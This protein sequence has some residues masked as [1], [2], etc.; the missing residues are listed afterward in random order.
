MAF[1]NN[2]IAGAAGAGSADDYLVNRSLRLDENTQGHLHFQPSQQGNRRKYTFSCWFKRAKLTG[3]GE[4]KLWGNS[5]SNSAYTQLYFTNTD[6]LVWHIQTGYLITDRHFK[7][8]SAWYHVVVQVDTDQAAAANRSK[9][10]INGELIQYPSE[11]SSMSW[12]S[13]TYQYN[14]T[15]NDTSKHTLSG[16]QDYSN[17]H[18]FDGL[19]AEVN[20]I[21]GSYLDASS[22]GLFH[23]DTGEWVPKKYSGSYGT[24]GYYLDFSNSS[25]IGEDQSGRGNN[26]TTANVD[27]G[28]IFKDSPT[29][30]EE[31][32][33]GN[34]TTLNFNDSPNVDNGSLSN[35]ALDFVG[36]QQ[37][38][39]MLRATQPI[40]STG[41]WY[42][43]AKFQG[44]AYN[45]RNLGSQHTAVGFCKTH[46]PITGITDG[47]STWIADS[48]YGTVFGSTRTDWHG[49][50]VDQGAVVGVAINR[51]ANQAWF[52]VNGVK[53]Q[54]AGLGKHGYEDLSPFVYSYNNT[55]ASL[56]CNFGQ[57][58]FSHYPV[59]SDFVENA[60]TNA[61]YNATKLFDGNLST[62]MS[63]GSFNSTAYWKPYLTDVT[64][65]RVYLQTGSR[66]EQIVIRGNLGNQTHTFSA[67]TSLSWHTLS[68]TN[69][70]SNLDIMEIGPR[71][72]GGEYIDVAAVEI[73]GTILTDSDSVGYKTINTANLDEPAIADPADAFNVQTYQGTSGEKAITTGFN[74]DIVWVKN[75]SQNRWH[76]LI[77]SI[78]GV[79]KNLYPNEDDAESANDTN[80]Y[81]SF[82]ATGYTLFGLDRDTNS[83]DGDN[84]ASWAWE[85]G[86]LATARDTTNYNQSQTWSS[87]VTSSNT[88]F[89]FPFETGF[90]GQVTGDGGVVG[91]AGWTSNSVTLTFSNLSASSQ[92]IVYAGSGLNSSIS[93]TINIGGSNYTH[94]ASSGYIN[95]LSFSYSGAVTTLALTS[96]GGGVRFYGI[97][98]DG[99]VLIDPGIIPI[100]DLNDLVYDRSQ[101]WSSMITRGS[102]W[103]HASN[104][105]YEWLL[106]GN[107]T[108]YEHAAANQTGSA[109]FSSSFPKGVIELYIGRGGGNGG[110][111]TVNG[112][113]I[114]ASDAPGHNWY[115]VSGNTLSS[116]S[117]TNPAQNVGIAAIRV[118]GKILADPSPS[119]DIT[120]Y[121][122]RPTKVT[123]NTSSGVSVSTYDGGGGY[124][125]F[126]HGL[127]GKQ[128]EMVI[129][130]A[131][132]AV[133]DWRV[134]HQH[135]DVTS[136]QNYYL[137][138]DQTTALSS[139][140]GRSLFDR[141]GPSPYVMHLGN[142]SAVNGAGRN[143]VAF[144]FAP[145]K[146]FS[147]FG[148]YRK[149]A[150][151]GPFA[152][153]GFRPAW[154]MIRRTDNS[155]S[156]VIYDE[157]R[158]PYNSTIYRLYADDVGAEGSNTSHYIDIFSNGFKVR[159]PQGNLL[160][161]SD[162]NAYY[163][164]A[165]FSSSPFKTSRAR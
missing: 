96:G 161:S 19:I 16:K 117:V 89:Q 127:N 123:A 138:W 20:F 32:D 150:G 120:N 25:N 101:T 28:D 139:D 121:P 78:R 64:S 103:H 39:S 97:K 147:E 41:K 116:I 61:S 153:C 35:G 122:G 81:K 91:F 135:L 162:T 98:V 82:D 26:W 4:H 75:R 119:Y 111:L 106:D 56:E 100:G 37:S 83:A 47:N 5:V 140:Q 128:P 77:D 74:P 84:Y 65:L 21:D 93:A 99:K 62:M 141:V 42:Y 49:A 60:S 46:E 53:K 51:E 112:F 70:G 76:R 3:T 151:D 145:V 24:N 15:I 45:P 118:N 155:N 38:Y 9:I 7:D 133:D 12:T 154:V 148:Y 54:V 105:F 6:K 134:F 132:N 63:H 67:N 2:V 107:L 129:I 8:T 14:T 66:Q 30:D 114:S 130:K 95:A 143:F 108:N 59:H 159:S 156:W 1:Y 92:V 72:G 142:D 160:N 48:G 40:P 163:V 102:G 68:L 36:D 158:D 137:K 34:Y 94:S 86:D 110:Q 23:A 80:N 125:S 43:E 27:S 33:V 144:S 136:P 164:W 50:D 157:A 44:N 17:S 115:R 85:A 55:A 146:G 18:Y 58:A 31:N 104:Y 73:N 165:A 13:S 71:G 131:R 11:Y 57:K 90:D 113:N 87:T 10:Y 79:A 29:N 88:N 52:F 124:L 149:T 69:T 22:F 126:A 152:Q 109:T